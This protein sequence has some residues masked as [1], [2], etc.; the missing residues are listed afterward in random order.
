MGW[1]DEQ[2]TNTGSARTMEQPAIRFRDVLGA[3]SVFKLYITWVIEKG[4]KRSPRL[5]DLGAC[6]LLKP[7]TPFGNCQ[8]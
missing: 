3:S 1:G 4:V 6:Q 7:L 2:C 8:N 5:S